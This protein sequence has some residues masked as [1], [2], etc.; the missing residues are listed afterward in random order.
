LFNNVV[1]LP[2][3]FHCSFEMRQVWVEMFTST[4]SGQ[5]TNPLSMP[6]RRHQQLFSISVWAGIVGDCLL[7]PQVLHAAYRR[8]LPK[9]HVKWFARST[10]RCTTCG[11]RKHMVPAWWCTSKPCCARCPRQYLS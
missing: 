2:F 7:G 1:S 11:L 3:F 5:R 8:P 10:R 4:T 6:L 9:S